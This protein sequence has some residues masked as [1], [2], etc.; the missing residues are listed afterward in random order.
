MSS[1]VAHGNI[2]EQAGKVNG[3]ANQLTERGMREGSDT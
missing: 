2:S 1:G 3:W